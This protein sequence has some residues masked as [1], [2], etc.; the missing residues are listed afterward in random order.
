[1]QYP[2]VPSDVRIFAQV[3]WELSVTVT[4]SWGKSA[5]ITS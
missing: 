4:F 5:R 3:A 1:M 2:S